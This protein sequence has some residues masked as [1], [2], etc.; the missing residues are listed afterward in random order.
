LGSLSNEDRTAHSDNEVGTYIH[1]SERDITDFADVGNAACSYYLSTSESNE[2]F[3]CGQT[4]V[5]CQL[6]SADA[7]TADELLHVLSNSHIKTVGN[8]SQQ[9][10]CAGN[11]TDAEAHSISVDNPNANVCDKLPGLCI[12]RV[13]FKAKLRVNVETLTELELWQKDFAER[14]KT[15]MRYANVSLCTGKK[16]LYK[17]NIVTLYVLCFYVFYHLTFTLPVGLSTSV[18]ETI[19]TANCIRKHK[20]TFCGMMIC[21]PLQNLYEQEL[22]YRK[23]IAC[24]LRTQYTE[25]IYKHKYYTMTLKSRLRVTQGHWKRN[26]WIDHTRLSSS[27]VI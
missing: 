11:I 10:S 26:H 19:R 15:T 3:V 4:G 24:Q 2:T 8:S 17:V 5:M 20:H 21:V 1:S 9:S 14:S 27:R 7:V 22:S 13:G 16:T 18:L 12:G 25:G 6:S 23:Q